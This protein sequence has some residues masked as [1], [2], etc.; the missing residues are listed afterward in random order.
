[1]SVDISR[2]T[3]PATRFNFRPTITPLDLIRKDDPLRSNYEKAM[4]PLTPARRRAVIDGFLDVLKE[5]YVDPAV[6][7]DIRIDLEAKM[8]NGEYDSIHDNE[9][10]SYQLSHDLVSHEKHMFVLFVEPRPELNHSDAGP[11]PQKHLEGLQ[12]MNF[13][14]GTTSLDTE[15]MPGHT[16]ATLPIN[17]FIPIDKRYMSDSE[18]I[19]AAVGD[20]MSSVS[21]ADALI[22][23]LRI[24]HGGDPRTVAFIESYLLDNAPLHVLDMVF[25]NGT[26]EKSHSTLTIDELP[27]EAKRFGGTKPLFVLTTNNTVSGGED[28]A[29]SLQSFKRAQ[30]IIG[31]GND[32]T[33]GAA[34]PIKTTRFVAEEIFGKGWWVVGVPNVRPVHAVTGVNWGKVGVKSDVVA[35]KGEWAEEKDAMEVA[36]QLAVRALQPDKEL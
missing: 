23:D 32:A 6:A 36:R 25:R 18:E 1:M 21:D 34:N 30:A 4:Q 27:A 31:E 17:S 16:I 28:L 10:F 5:Q 2:P 33:A 7:E 20:I 35:G 29:Y 9:K 3:Y 22:I 11:A 19:Q 13:G 24:N 8:G 26:V 12:R 14:F 15:S